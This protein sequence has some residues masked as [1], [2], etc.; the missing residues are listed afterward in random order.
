M[1]SR[2]G[3]E[4]KWGVGGWQGERDRRI[5]WI[6]GWENNVAPLLHTLA[7]GEEGGGRG[8]E[9]SGERGGGR[10]LSDGGGAENEK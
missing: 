5:L 9:G 2:E 8:G 1:R 10:W 6:I 3:V 4:G 7:A